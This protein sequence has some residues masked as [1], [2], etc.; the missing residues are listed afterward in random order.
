[1]RVS[2]FPTVALDIVVICALP[3]LLPRTVLAPAAP[4]LAE[5]GVSGLL[6]MVNGRKGAISGGT[7]LEKH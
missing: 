6:G 5:S 7:P 1:M 2:F 4:H 3:T